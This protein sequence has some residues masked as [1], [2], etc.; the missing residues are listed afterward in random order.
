VSFVDRVFSCLFSE[1]KLHR[2]LQLSGIAYALSEETVKVEQRRCAKRVDVV[3]AVESIE[4]F[5]DRNKRTPLAKLEWPLQAPIKREVLIVF[6]R[7]VA[8]WAR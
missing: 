7:I 8:S 5:H 1:R 6:P 2:Q 3:L 4:H